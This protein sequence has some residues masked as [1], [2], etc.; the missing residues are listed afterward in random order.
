MDFD[1]LFKARDYLR[2]TSHTPG[3][4]RIKVN[5]AILSTPGF[6][7]MPKFDTLPNGID[8]VK[9]NIFTQTLTVRYQP[10]VIAPELLDELLVT[11]DAARGRVIVDDLQQRLGVTIC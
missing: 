7:Q 6:S 1:S 4:L 3:D 2:V 5:P 11:T 10:E 9:V 8:D